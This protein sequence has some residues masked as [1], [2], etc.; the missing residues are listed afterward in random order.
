M[1][2][3]TRCLSFAPGR[4]VWSRLVQR[5]HLRAPGSFSLGP[6]ACRTRQDSE[7]F[8]GDIPS[9][10]V[11]AHSRQ[12]CDPLVLLDFLGVYVSI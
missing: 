12:S 2:M 3:M 5:E 7:V 11:C 10:H 1:G 4:G 6:R 8:L 9:I